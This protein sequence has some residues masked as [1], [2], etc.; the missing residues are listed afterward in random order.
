MVI[1]Y[2]YI[3]V[4]ELSLDFKV[5]RLLREFFNA[6]WNWLASFLSTQLSCNLFVIG[7]LAFVIVWNHCVSK[8]R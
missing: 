6:I 4:K 3:T 1:I 2:P 8:I 7:I 5:L